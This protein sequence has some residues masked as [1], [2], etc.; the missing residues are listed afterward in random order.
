MTRPVY[1]PA[2]RGEVVDTHHGVSVEDPY[3]WLEHAD[4]PETREWIAAQ[5]QLTERWLR[6]VEGREAIRSR[7]RE[8]T[9]HPRAGAP[10][11]RGDRWFALRN[12][13]LQ[14][15]DVLWTMTA[16][17][18]D[19]EVLLDPNLLSADGTV[20]LTAVVVSEDGALL[21][22]A[23]SAAGSDWLEWQVRDVE[24]GQELGDLVRWSKFSGAAWAPDNSGFF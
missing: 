10:W 19:G 5:N 12:T 1:P 11:R 16:A 21:A 17:D 9:N 2:R 3:R 4:A 13:G 6:E 24:T 23:T 22:Y 8:L 18:Q 7:L 15:Q 20:A 14:N